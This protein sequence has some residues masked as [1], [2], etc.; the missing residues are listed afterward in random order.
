M[1]ISLE[2]SIYNEPFP[3]TVASRKDVFVGDEGAA[4]SVGPVVLRG[5]QVQQSGPWELTDLGLLA[6][7]GGGLEMFI[8]YPFGKLIFYIMIFRRYYL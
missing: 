7:S 3:E 6:T 1:K 4:T 5:S 2:S 8:F